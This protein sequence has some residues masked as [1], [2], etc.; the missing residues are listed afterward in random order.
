MPETSCEYE[1]TADNAAGRSEEASREAGEEKKHPG[2]PPPFLSKAA[3]R[4]KEI[5]RL[6]K[7]GKDILEKYQPVSMILPKLKKLLYRIRPRRLT[8]DL[9]FGFA[10]PANTGM[11]I[12]LISNL[13][14]LYRYE[15]FHIC[16]DFETNKAYVSGTFSAE[17]RIRLFAVL[18][19]V[20]ALIKEKEF[21][22]LLKALKKI[23]GGIS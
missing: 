23:N 6:L 8:G 17:G 9:V 3:D 21:R 5:I 10:D 7:T 11:L 16:G 14:F 20:I 13:Y 19:F 22:Q 15:N 1:G 2:F 12:G 4:L 18:I